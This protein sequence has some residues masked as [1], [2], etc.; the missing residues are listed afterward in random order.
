MKSPV[1]PWSRRGIRAF[2]LIEL[3]VVIAIIAVLIS[4]LL[5]AVQSAREAARRAQCVNN[6]KQLALAAANYEGSAGVY[7]PGL[8]WCILTGQL[9]GYV[10][11][12]CGPMPHLAPYLEQGQVYNSIN[13]QQAIYYN[14]N[15][16][17]HAIGLSTLWCPSDGTISEV[18]SLSDP[19][20]SGNP[21]GYEVSPAGVFRMAYSS[22]AGVCGP[23][24]PNTW[25]IAGVG[26]RATHGQIKAN[27]LGIFGVCS[28]TRISSITDGTSNTMI[29]GEHGHGLIA[30]ASQP[31][32]QWWDSGNLGDTLITTMFPLNPQRTVKD[33]S[34]NGVGGSV[35]VNSAS[36]L[37]PG[38]A[39]FAFV[40]GSVRFVKDS[41]QS[42]Q[43]T[44]LGTDGN[45]GPIP[46]AVTATVAT[47]S[48]SPNPFWDTVY[49]VKP[50]FQFGVYQ[51]LSTRNAG[52]I[53]SADSF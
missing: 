41:T 30:A 29:F 8:Y 42:W 32:W 50:G 5:P 16:T 26:S 25:S 23:W 13:F 51:A 52:E 12:N 24:F 11:T 44:P 18:Q 6:L 20:S 38:G 45:G 3:L 39:N 9:A 34:G 14:V 47:G 27:E 19:D 35:F 1:R 28:N 15:L 40:D 10:G 43:I 48:A 21:R 46:A 33:G 2:T 4:L 37:H 7:P 22:Y 31:L 49:S 36:S 17:I 53:I